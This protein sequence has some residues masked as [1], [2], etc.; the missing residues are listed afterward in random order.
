MRVVAREKTH[1][2]LLEAAARLFRERGFVAVTIRERAREVGKSTGAIF[3]HFSGKD[4]VW[5]AA[6]N[7]PPP[8]IEMAEKL[9]V[10]QSE[11]PG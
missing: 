11:H 1:R 8:D 4:A 3:A 5:L 7:S 10:L 9:A 2:D 6:M